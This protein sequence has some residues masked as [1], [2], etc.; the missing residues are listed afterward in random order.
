MCASWVCIW[1][2]SG[3]SNQDR[4]QIV[5]QRGRLK[6]DE[7]RC[8]RGFSDHPR[9][10][11]F[12]CVIPTHKQ[13]FTRLWCY[14]RS[15][16]PENA[17]NNFF[18]V[19][20]VAAVAEIALF[21]SSLF[22]SLLSLFGSGLCH[23]CVYNGEFWVSASECAEKVGDLQPYPPEQQVNLGCNT[24]DL[25]VCHHGSLFCCFCGLVCLRKCARTLW[26]QTK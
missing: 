18:F 2:R 21:Y 16:L 6:G 1:R 22:I 7:S 15:S 26:P 24:L 25:Y 3:I 23:I 12:P 14:E 10:L 17:S 13:P 11:I 4:R 20:V 5:P 9:W 19:V 8:R